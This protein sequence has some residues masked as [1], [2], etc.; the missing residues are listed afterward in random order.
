MSDRARLSKIDSWTS[1]SP[2]GLH[3]LGS[4]D[5]PTGL[6]DAVRKYDPAG[7]F[8]EQFQAHADENY[9]RIPSDREKENLL[10]TLKRS[11]QGKRILNLAG[12]ADKLVPHRL[13]KPFLDWLKDAASPHGI[14][15][16]E[17]LVIEEIVYDGVGHE[18][19]PA[20]VADMDR[21]ID[22]SLRSRTIE[23]SAKLSKI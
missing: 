10:S 17:G 11:L 14:F 4:K 7:L 1:S 23:P 20:M 15:G 22:E 16:N 19:A 2:P 5:F 6:I 8:M 21:F 12:G 13:T 3:F 18:M 9:T